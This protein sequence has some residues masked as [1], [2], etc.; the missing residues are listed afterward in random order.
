TVGDPRLSDIQVF[1]REGEQ[2]HTMRAGA[3]HPLEQWPA[4]ARQPAFPLSLSADRELN[5]LIRVASNTVVIIEPRLW[6]ELG[7][8]EHRQNSAMA[9]GMTLGITLLMVPFSFVVGW[10]LRS[11]LLVAHA[12]TLVAYAM[13]V[14]VVNGYL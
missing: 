12:L 2:W 6:S 9:D 1:V 14:S 4:E 3:E 10:I 8:L 13:L 11:R 5:L 7:L